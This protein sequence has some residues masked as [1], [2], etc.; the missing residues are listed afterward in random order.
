MLKRLSRYLEDAERIQ[1][2]IKS[3]MIYPTAVLTIGA[4]VVGVMLTLV[5]PKFEEMLK[6]NNQ[7]L[8][9]PTQIVI[10]A[11]HFMINNIAVILGGGSVLIYLLL[12]YFRSVEGRAVRDRMF[13]SMPIFGPIIKMAGI[14]RFC[15]TLQTLLTSG[16]N[17]IDAIEICRS[18]IDNVVL[19]EATAKI[20]TDIEGGQTLGM[21]IKKITVFPKMTYQMIQVGEST[22]SL[23]KMLEKIADFYEADVESL[24]AGLSKLI[25]PVILVF[26]GG[27]VGGMMMAMYLPIFKLASGG[28][29]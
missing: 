23:D 21:S 6:G 7:E 8:P 18:A 4:L 12:R 9:L 20:R 25:E 24:V 2:Q 3:A 1:K 28:G 22:G 10:T 13:F 5:I 29:E 27:T 14:A 16:V 11:S 15:R 19:E 26:L 17:L